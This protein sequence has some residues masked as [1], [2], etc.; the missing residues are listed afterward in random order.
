VLAEIKTLSNTSGEAKQIRLGIGQLLDYQHRLALAG[1]DVEAA[2]VLDRE[3]ADSHWTDLCAEHGI[4]LSWR[5]I[6]H[7]LFE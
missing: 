1:A 4:R 3:P 6:L 5:E 7:E 2:L